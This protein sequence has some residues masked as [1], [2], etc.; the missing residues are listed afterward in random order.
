MTQQADSYFG[1][2]GVENEVSQF[3]VGGLEGWC[4]QH[5]RRYEGGSHMKTVW[6]G[7]KVEGFDARLCL[8]LWLQGSEV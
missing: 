4:T 8:K 5:R 6:E 7:S 1:H 3:Y 2:G